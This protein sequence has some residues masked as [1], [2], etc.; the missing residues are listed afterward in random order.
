MRDELRQETGLKI[1]GKPIMHGLFYNNNVSKKDH[2]LAYQCEVQGGLEA[3]PKSIEI[4]EIGYFS[5]EDLP[6]DTDPGTVRRIR[7][8]VFGDEKTEVW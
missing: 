3:R 5:F 1:V 8:M 7:E 2:V 6:L 4:A